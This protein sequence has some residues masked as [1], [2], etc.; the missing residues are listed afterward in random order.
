[1]NLDILLVDSHILLVVD[2]HLPVVDSHILV[3]VDLH[4]PVVDLHLPVVDFV[5]SRLS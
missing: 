5:G 3:V 4:F 1:M 2:S